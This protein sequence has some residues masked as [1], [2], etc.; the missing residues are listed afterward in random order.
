MNKKQLNISP[1]YA[2]Q[3]LVKPF[4]KPP[5][6]QNFW[7]KLLSSDSI[8]WKNV[9]VLAKNCYIVLAR[10]SIQNIEQNWGK[11]GGDHFLI[12]VTGESDTKTFT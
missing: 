10:I 2:Y 4:V 9:N 8:E 12:K 7:E 6:P 3:K 5:A 11:G 1:K